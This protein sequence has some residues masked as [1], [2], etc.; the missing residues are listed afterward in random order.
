MVFLLHHLS[1]ALTL[2]IWVLGVAGGVGLVG[3]SGSPETWWRGQ[4]SSRIAS[5]LWLGPSPCVLEDNV[6]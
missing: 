3:S 6:W 4:I 1:L 2:C 5:S